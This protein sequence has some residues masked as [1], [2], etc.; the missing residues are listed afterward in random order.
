MPD[1]FERLNYTPDAS[2]AGQAGIREV[3]HVYPTILGDRWGSTTTKEIKVSQKKRLF[4]R[5]LAPLIL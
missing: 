5:G 3:P 1:L 2:Q 4:F